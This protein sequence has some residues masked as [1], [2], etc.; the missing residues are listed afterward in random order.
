MSRLRP[1]KAE[2]MRVNTVVL[3]SDWLPYAEPFPKPLSDSYGFGSGSRVRELGLRARIKVNTL[4]LR[5]PP[6]YPSAPCLFCRNVRTTPAVQYPLVPGN[7][8]DT[9]R[10]ST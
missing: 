10:V 2:R 7:P 9:I 3:L 8:P 6:G 4:L 5:E 1:T